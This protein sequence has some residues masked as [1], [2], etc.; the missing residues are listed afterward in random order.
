MNESRPLRSSTFKSYRPLAQDVR[1]VAVRANVCVCQFSGAR[2]RAGDLTQEFP[3]D[4][5]NE[6]YA[7][8][9]L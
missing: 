3:G 5:T 9:A 1:R 4:L 2:Y 8:R 7:R 6:Q